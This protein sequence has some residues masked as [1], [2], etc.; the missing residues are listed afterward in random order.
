M[1]EKEERLVEIHAIFENRKDELSEWEVNFLNNIVR[2]VEKGWKL[3]P[4]QAKKL[5]DI[6][7][8]K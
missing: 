8:G 2:T 6:A 4:K 7:E 1:S 3:S 5:I